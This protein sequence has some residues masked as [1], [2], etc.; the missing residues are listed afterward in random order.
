M[1]GQLGDGT[2]TNRAFPVSI[3][4]S[5]T[6]TAV[7]A[8]ASHTVAIKSDGTLWAWGL[9][10]SG[11]LGDGTTA[12]KALPEQI[13][14]NTNW[15]SVAAGG[16]HT[17]AVRSDGSLWAWGLNDSGEVGDGT[18]AN[19]AVPTQ[20]G[21]SIPWSFI[22]AGSDHSAAIRTDETLWTWGSNV[23]E[24]LGDGLTANTT[25]PGQIGNSV[26]W[27]AIA[28]GSDHSAA[29]ATDGTLWAWGLNLS[30]QV[31]DGTTTSRSSPVQ[32]GTGFALPPEVVFTVP[33]AGST[34]AAAGTTIQT[35]FSQA[36]DAATI[37]ASTFTVSGGVPGAVAYDG[38]TNI[39]TFTPSTPLAPATAYT[40]TITTGVADASGNSLP[41]DFTWTFTTAQ[42]SSATSGGGG[43]G[44]H[45]FIATAAYG[46]YLDPHVRV[47]RD[48]RDRY[49]MTNTP[50]RYLVRTYYRYSPPIA[51]SIEGNRVLKA[52]VRSILTP[53]VYGLKRPIAALFFLLLSAGAIIFR[54]RERCGPGP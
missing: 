20:I 7:A 2:T 33:P 12:D 26:N 51:H 5:E 52:L 14:S 44:G 49:L 47:L 17:V 35:T 50:G 25:I 46:S 29:I 41:A 34:N 27:R 8:G 15:R 45:C 43:G 18:T 23:D 6:W 21:V 53:L 54:K 11:Q 28:A 48:F 22:A 9:N 3:G 37:N 31:G 10:M 38:S 4:G 42:A 1:S 40:A 36:M 19:I 39:A 24:Q 16:G 30:G 32:V 13:G